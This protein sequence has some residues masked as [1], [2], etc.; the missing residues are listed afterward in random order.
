GTVLPVVCSSGEAYFLTTAPAGHNLYLCPTPNTWSLQ[1]PQASSTTLLTDLQVNWTASQL[2]IGAGCSVSVPCLATMGNT[3]YMITTPPSAT[4]AA[5][6]GTA[7]AYLD[8]SGNLTV[9]Y[10]ACASH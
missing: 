7:Y 2:T 10:G 8:T 5:N 3:T 4:I 6:G 1:G 9:G